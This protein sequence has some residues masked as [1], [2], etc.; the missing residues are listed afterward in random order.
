MAIVKWKNHSLYDPWTNLKSLQDEINSLFNTDR[1][2]SS[3]GLFD[4]NFSPSIDVVENENE[5]AV[6]CELPGIELQDIDVSIASNVLTVKG[7]KQT[8]QKKKGKYYR[9]ETWEGSFQRT[10]SLPSSIDPTAISAEFEDG[11][12]RISIPKKDEA[13][14]KQITVNIK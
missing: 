12:L 2:P 1:L 7:D 4:R 8:E 13:R 9:N 3:T 10:L 6:F 14:T 11:I 5:F